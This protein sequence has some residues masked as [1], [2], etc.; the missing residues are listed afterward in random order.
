MPMP[1]TRTADVRNFIH[2]RGP[3]DLRLGA[4]RQFLPLEQTLEHPMNTKPF[5]IACLSLAALVGCSNGNRKAVAVDHDNTAMNQRDRD[6]TTKTPLDQSEKTED[7]KITAAIRQRLQKEE[8][9]VNAKNMKII[10]QDGEVTLR[11]PVKSQAE[12]DLA[13]QLAKDVAGSAKVHN[14]LDVEQQP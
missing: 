7:V 9:S 8:V 14:E 6:K 4:P 10:T 2:C 12:K 5:A 3:G 11:G 1:L 13:E